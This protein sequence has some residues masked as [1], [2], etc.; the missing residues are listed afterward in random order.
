M[1]KLH[2]LQLVFLFLLSQNVFSQKISGKVQLPDG[3][4]AEYA[5]VLLLNQKDSSLANKAKKDLEFRNFAS[6]LTF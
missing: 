5:A 4:P 2:L 1:K 6:A 3:K